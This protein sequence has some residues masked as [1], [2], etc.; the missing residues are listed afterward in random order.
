MDQSFVD[1]E[2]VAHVLSIFLL[3]I[4]VE[5]IIADVQHFKSLVFWEL[6]QNMEEPS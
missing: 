3:V 6:F 5:F 1:L 4:L 2:H